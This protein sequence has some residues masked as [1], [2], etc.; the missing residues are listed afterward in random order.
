MMVN[1]THLQIFLGVDPVINTIRTIVIWD[2]R[3]VICLNQLQRGWT[4]PCYSHTSLYVSRVRSDI[5]YSNSQ[6]PSGCFFLAGW[7]I[8]SVIHWCLLVILIFVSFSHLYAMRPRRYSFFSVK[9]FDMG[10]TSHPMRAHKSIFISVILTIEL[11]TSFAIIQL[12]DV[13]RMGDNQEF[14]WSILD[15]MLQF[16]WYSSH[17]LTTW[18]LWHDQWLMT[19]WNI[20]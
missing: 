12:Q 5:K 11:D 19:D 7:K 9:W 16:L 20:S 6:S 13:T 1:D 2:K 10:S 17:I 8:P 14:I 18:R 15:L 3:P 4:F